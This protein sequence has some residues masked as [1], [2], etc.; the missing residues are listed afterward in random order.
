MNGQTIHSALKIP[1]QH[2]YGFDEV[3]LSS[4]TLN[5]L[6]SDLKDIH[7]I[8]IDEISMVSSKMLDCVNL[9]LQT[10]FDNTLPFAGLNVILV[11]DFFKLRP[12]KGQFAFK[13][14]LLWAIF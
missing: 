5:S 13:H 8:I 4:R 1:V 2:S 11:G 6:R 14:K 12:V 3:E 9:R 10:I 7:T